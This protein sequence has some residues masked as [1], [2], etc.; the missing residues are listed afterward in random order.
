MVS[1]APLVIGA[2]VAY[3]GYRYTATPTT[4]LVVLTAFIAL[5]HD[6]I[7]MPDNYNYGLEDLM[8]DLIVA[9][10]WVAVSRGD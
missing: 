4:K 10:A 1:F 3:V 9:A 2:P 8:L 6:E 7:I 5:V